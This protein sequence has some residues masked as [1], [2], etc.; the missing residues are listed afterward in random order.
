VDDA[1]QL[2]GIALFAGLAEEHLA[3]LAAAL[4]R[5]RYPR[6]ATVFLTGDPGEQLYL[7]ERGRVRIG[8]VAPDGR[9]VVLAVLGPGEAF[10]DLALLDG[11]PRSADAAAQEDSLLLVLPRDAF[12]RHLEAHPGLA[13]ALLAE[14]SRRLRRNARIIQDAAFRDVPARLAAALLQLARE[15]GPPDGSG[16]E[17]AVSVTQAELAGMIGATRESVNKW[18]G[19]FERRGFLRRQRGVIAIADTRALGQQ[20]LAP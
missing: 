20:L 12:L 16:R 10:G 4:R 14:M 6:G 8:L 5:R 11:E 15:Q 3:A 19:S 7:I 13:I 1:E 9:E 17:V 18:L 2:R